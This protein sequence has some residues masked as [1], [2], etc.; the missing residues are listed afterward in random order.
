MTKETG[1]EGRFN[2]YETYINHQETARKL[3]SVFEEDCI[4]S[5][6]VV[7]PL[8]LIL[9]SLEASIKW[10]IPIGL[11]GFSILFVTQREK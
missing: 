5:A 11:R 4:F 2:S 3:R 6:L 1:A 10:P 7:F 8:F 9:L